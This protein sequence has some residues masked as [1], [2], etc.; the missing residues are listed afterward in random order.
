MR[1]SFTVS[2][3]LVIFLPGG[4]SFARYRSN[5]LL[6]R[7]IKPFVAFSRFFSRVYVVS[8]ASHLYLEREAIQSFPV[9][10]LTILCNF[11]RLPYRL[12]S[13]LAPFIFFR[14]FFHADLYYIDQMDG[15]L[16]GIIAKVIF[17]KR[18]VIRCGYELLSFLELQNATRLKRLVVEKIEM[19][20][21]HSADRIIVSSHTAKNFIMQKFSP[22]VHSKIEVIPNW[23]DTTLFYP[24]KR[25]KKNINHF[26]SVGRL[27]NQKNYFTLIDAIASTGEKLTIIGSGFLR[28]ALEQYAAKL[29]VDVSIIAKIANDELPSVLC[30]HHIFIFP[31]LYEGC[32]KALLE[33]MA[34]GLA[35]IASDCPG[36]R[37][38]V[39]HEKNGI[40]VASTKE[41][42][43]EGIK[44]LLTNGSLL[45][46]L[47]QQAVCDIRVRYTL[48]SY[49]EKHHIIFQALL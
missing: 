30:G 8:Y 16:P 33:A 19:A 38:I 31:S 23:I 4:M 32:P 25:P 26:I 22:K 12:Y 11:F 47:G 18:T 48:E 29:S 3:T 5:G 44:K 17:R 14:H 2:S 13:L 39:H 27:A 36:N 7:E 15:A 49:I 9:T 10:N 1:K 41:G 35:V 43:R 42:L 45:S 40:L 34:C 6:S 46:R 21:Y 24:R 20:A 37:E 28:D